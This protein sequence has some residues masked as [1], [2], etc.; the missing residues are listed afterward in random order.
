RKGEEPR[1]LL[2]GGRGAVMPAGDP[3]AGQRLIVA[4]DLEDTG[5]EAT[6]RLAAAISDAD[7]RRAHGD[8]IHW[9]EMA[10]WSKRARLVEARRREM[11][12]AIALTDQH[13]RDVPPEALGAALA[14]G[15]RE[16]GLE[17]IPWTTSATALRHRIAWARKVDADLP[18]CSDAAL[19]DTLDDWLTPHLAGLTRIEQIERLDL[20]QLLLDRLDWDAQKTLDRIAPNKFTTPLGSQARIDYGSETPKISLKVQELFGVT[21]HPQAAG[22]PLLIELLSPAGRPVQTTRDLPGFWRGSYGDVAKDMRA[23]YPKHPWPEDP[24]AAAPTRRAKRRA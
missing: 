3:L 10:E 23:R 21:Q 20:H 2:S 16:R 12:G 17:A 14:D 5:R 4:A 1:Y 19:V 15:V 22:Q 9:V 13:W 18:N 11:L 8:Q 7:L 6:I 24:A